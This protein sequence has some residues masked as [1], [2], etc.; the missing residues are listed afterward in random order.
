[1]TPVQLPPSSFLVRRRKAIMMAFIP[2]IAFCIATVVAEIAGCWHLRD[3]VLPR[4]GFGLVVP[5]YLLA[6]VWL[7]VAEARWH[8]RQR[9]TASG[10]CLVCGYDLRATPERC[11]ECGTPI[12]QPRDTGTNAD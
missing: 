4:I 2:A 8:Y 10:L 5:M 7:V 9:R 1:M 3:D 12:S 6:I 11:P